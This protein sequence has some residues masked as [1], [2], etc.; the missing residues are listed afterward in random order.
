V[1]GVGIKEIKYERTAWVG[2]NYRDL[3]SFSGLYPAKIGNFHLT[4]RFLS[5][6]K[7]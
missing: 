3:V 1:E 5:G 4:E 6:D 7:R 2:Y